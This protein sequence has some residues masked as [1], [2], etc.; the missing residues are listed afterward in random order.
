MQNNKRNTDVISARSWLAELL[1]LRG[2][3]NNTPNGKP[4]YTYHLTEQEYKELIEIVSE[5]LQNKYKYD[6][7]YYESACFCLFVSEYYRRD[8]NGN[9]SWSGPEEILQ[10]DLTPASR[11]LLT[12]NGMEYWKREIKNN[13]KGRDFLGSLFAEGGLPWSQ[14]RDRTSSF[15]RVVHSGIR[16]H[17]KTDDKTR[18]TLDV[19]EEFEN[20]LPLSFRTLHTRQIL[21]SVVDLLMLLVSEYSLNE[22]ENPAAF[23]DKCKPNWMS[24]F[25]IPIDEDNARNLINEWLKDA[26]ITR[27]ERK[28]LLDQA[29]HYTCQHSLQLNL[30]NWKIE[31]TIYLPKTLE[32]DLADISL[33]STRLEVMYFEGE[34]ILARGG[35]VYGRVDNKVLK[36]ILN[37]SEVVLKRR[38]LSFP[39]TFRL[40]NNGKVIFHQYIDGS[41]LEVNEY[42]LIFF[43]DN[44]ELENKYLLG[45]IASCS[46]STPKALIRLPATMGLPLSEHTLIGTDNEDAKWL[47]VEKDTVFCSDD[48]QYTI[49][50]SQPSYN[51]SVRLDG[52]ITPYES[53]PSVTYLGWPKLQLS[54]D[55]PYKK[56]ELVEWVN[57]EPI[58]KFKKHSYVGIVNYTLRSPNGDSLLRR[59]FAVLPE[60]F[61]ITLTP[62]INQNPAKVRVGGVA[63]DSIRILHKDLRCQVESDRVGVS[64]ST[65][66]LYAISDTPPVSFEIEIG[67]E[68]AKKITLQV[69]YPHLGVRL[70]DA[71]GQLVEDRDITIKDLFS[72]SLV[73]M[74]AKPSGEDFYIDLDLVCETI[75]HP[76]KSVLIKVGSQS[77]TIMFLSYQADILQ[78]LASEKEQDTYVKLEIS[79]DIVLRRLNVH[80]YNGAINK[81][82]FNRYSIIDHEKKMVFGEV[83]AEAMHLGEPR[84][85]PIVIQLLE[86]DQGPAIFDMPR[87]VIEKT[88]PWLIYPTQSSSIQFRPYLYADERVS[89]LVRKNSEEVSSIYQ[90]TQSYHPSLNPG[91]IDEHVRLMSRDVGHTN[92]QYFADLKKRYSHLPL[93]SFEAWKALANNY[94]ALSLA[95]LRLGMD[96]GFCER[97]RDELAVVWEAIPLECWR[98]SYT[99]YIDF[100]RQSGLS[101]MLLKQAVSISDSTLKSVIP[102]FEHIENYLE[103]G[104][105]PQPLPFRATAILPIWYQQHCQFHS[106]DVRWPTQ[107]QLE[108]EVWM[109]KNNI[110]PIILKLP[111]HNYQKS[112]IY[113]PIF[114]AYVTAGKASLE[115]LGVS[116]PFLKFSIRQIMEFDRTNWFN[117]V[118]A[119]MVHSLMFS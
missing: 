55:F 97:V 8:Y 30:P 89:E 5:V 116:L 13:D 96:I 12:A 68:N 99:L 57:G 107:L 75:P 43:Q 100:L 76:K 67:A 84:A 98:Y 65:Y 9:W 31:S 11:E 108:L 104:K 78:M 94:E 86:E 23:L 18:S 82:I 2:L 111:Q 24:D 77:E 112:V 35:V 95:V 4:L 6:L 105:P 15:A 44:D 37:Q 74:S 1:L 61:S 59:R 70:F 63:Q 32:L 110:D 83:G 115:E 93:S 102:G 42:P 109:Q 7:A 29:K 103:S 19:L 117:P 119:L 87:K 71:N 73:L 90:A 64:G 27:R 51:Q 88:G 114:M 45:G 38:D 22:Q 66:H 46:I 53:S 41:E 113:L 39:L 79:T 62:S 36:V 40:V 118:H 25:P 10:V 56:E 20:Y 26:I 14:F 33:Q 16:N 69:P 81:E 85:E 60:S 52:V 3:Y 34:N 21:A 72:Y 28:E 91:I 48:E 106:N 49:K 47:S 58:H 80:R 50:L 92:W 54:E 101:E 17:Y